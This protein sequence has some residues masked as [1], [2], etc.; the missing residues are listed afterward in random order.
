MSEFQM[1]VQRDDKHNKFWTYSIESGVYFRSRWG[2][3]GTKGSSSSK[4]FHSTY[5]AEEHARRKLVSKINKGYESVTEEEFAILTIQAGVVGSGNKVEYA[6]IVVSTTDHQAVDVKPEVFVNPDMKPSFIITIRTREA[7]HTFHIR[8]EGTFLLA[9][10][11]MGRMWKQPGK[12]LFLG[13]LGI[14]YKQVN[15]VWAWSAARKINSSHKLY[16]LVAQ[17]QEVVGTL[18]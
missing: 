1:W 15:W 12:P 14:E 7:E 17:V 13:T 5:A 2:R 16:P 4:Q 11:R 3:I 9:Q 6:S 18:L 10:A 8:E